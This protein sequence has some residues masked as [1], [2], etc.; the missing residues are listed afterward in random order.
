[1]MA[2]PEGYRVFGGG[3]ISLDHSGR[4]TNASLD[5]LNRAMQFLHGPMLPVRDSSG[6]FLKLGA[7]WPKFTDVKTAAYDAQVGEFVRANGGASGSRSTFPPAPRRMI[8]WACTRQ[9]V[10]EVTVTPATGHTVHGSANELLSAGKRRVYQF[11]GGS[12]WVRVIEA[13]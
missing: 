11:D 1:M 13:G 8:W 7:S 12:N 5:N 9:A 4:L 10:W 3:R 6:S 2:A